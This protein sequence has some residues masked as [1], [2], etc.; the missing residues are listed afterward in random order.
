MLLLTFLISQSKLITDSSIHPLPTS[1]APSAHIPSLILDLVAEDQSAISL[2]L[3]H[4]LERHKLKFSPDKIDTM[5]EAITD[6]DDVDEA[7][8][9]HA[10]RIKRWYGRHVPEMTKI[11][12]DNILQARLS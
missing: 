2:G 7:L 6:L 10:T 1:A 12:N 3:S 4:S 9:I 11:I 8:N 5:I